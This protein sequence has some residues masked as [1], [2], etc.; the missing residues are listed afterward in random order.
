MIH[1]LHGWVEQKEEENQTL[2]AIFQ[3]HL[4]CFLIFGK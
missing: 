3:I 2:R 4:L 1:K